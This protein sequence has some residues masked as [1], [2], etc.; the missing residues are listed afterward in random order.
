MVGTKNCR[1][2][3]LK[4]CKDTGAF[5]SIRSDGET[6]HIDDICTPENLLPDLMQDAFWS[7]KL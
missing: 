2:I 4:G 7:T 6:K 1:N 3:K 5:L